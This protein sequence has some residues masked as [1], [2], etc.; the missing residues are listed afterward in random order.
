MDRIYTKMDVIAILEKVITMYDHHVELESKL[1]D[2]GIWTDEITNGFDAII[3]ELLFLTGNGV[4]DAIYDIIG[5][6]TLKPKLRAE[7]IY[8]LRFERGTK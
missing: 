3:D 7:I 2:L 6:K 8:G 1:A 4:A 5:E